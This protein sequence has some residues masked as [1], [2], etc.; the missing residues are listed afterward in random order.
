MNQDRY[1]ELTH[2]ALQLDRTLWTNGALTE[3]T[4]D[5]ALHIIDWCSAIIF[6]L[7]ELQKETSAELRRI[8]SK[9]SER[10]Y[11]S[12]LHA[13]TAE[14]QAAQRREQMV[15][16]AMEHGRAMTL[17]QRLI[18]LFEIEPKEGVGEMLIKGEAYIRENRVEWSVAYARD[19]NDF[20]NSHSLGRTMP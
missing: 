2:A 12:G 19:A 7:G 9:Y 6:A 1:I 14:W 4:R 11:A 18:A 15:V 3:M 5:E 16:D 20:D 13:R 8:E 17:I 10:E